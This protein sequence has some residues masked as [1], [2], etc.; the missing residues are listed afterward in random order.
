MSTPPKSTYKI[1]AQY[2]GPIMS[3]TGEL[4]WKQQNL[5]FARNGTGKSFL[6]RALRHLDQHGQ[7]N[8]LPDAASQLVS[9]ESID[10]QGR[11][12]IS[13]GTDELGALDLLRSANKASA[14]VAVDTVF[15]VFN[16]EFV[17]EQLRE[18][19]Y[20]LDGNIEHEI[21]VDK[22]NIQ[23]NLAKEAV[24]SAQ[25]DEATGYDA[26][27]QSFNSD[28]DANLRNRANIN[29]QLK[30]YKD[31]SLGALLTNHQAKPD[32]NGQS[33]AL[34]VSELD[35]LKSIPS[36]PIYPETIDPLEES[37]LAFKELE[38]SLQRVTSPS[39]VAYAIK[40]RI[41]R[42]H[43]FYET[44]TSLIKE[45]GGEKCPLC[46]QDI[47][48]GD[49]KA[50]IDAYVAYFDDEE[51]RHKQELRSF[52]KRLQTIRDHVETTG[53]KIAR[54]RK[55]FDDLKAF[56]PSMRSIELTP[57]SSEIDFAMAVIEST[58]QAISAKIDALSLAS[59]LGDQDLSRAIEKLNIAI[60]EN[61]QKAAALKKSVEQSDDERL[62]L[63]RSACQIFEKEF[64]IS[65]W[66][67]L[68]ELRALQQAAK[69]RTTELEDIERSNPSTQAKERVADTF[70]L[71]LRE[72]F[73]EKYRFDRS[74][75]VLTRGENEMTRGTNQT[76]SDGEKTAIAF[77]YFIAC[78]HLKVKTNRDYLKLFL[79]F[80]DPVTSMSFDF[81]YAIAQTL[82]NMSVSDA[83][84]ISVNPSVRDGGGHKRPR[85]LVL[86]HSSYFFNICVTNRVIAEIATFSLS[87]EG[88][89][90]TVA[91]LD[92]Y[93]APFQQQLKDIFEISEGRKSP[94]HSTGNA[95]RS[96]LEA[97]GRFC[98]PDKT[99]SLT[100]FITF[101]AGEDG[102][103][104]RSVLIN[105]LSHG[106]FYDESP[107]PDDLRLACKETVQ[108][109]ERYARGQIEML[110]K[111]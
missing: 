18:K 104:L 81:I 100:N 84:E 72:F 38:H 42:H 24:S 63:Q 35:K 16:D 99:D 98:R 106:T 1:H 69:D 96:V 87:N 46:E 25:Q 97:V 33:I 65:H 76:L 44:G 94:D 73:S 77:C 12:T 5:I 58:Q 15:H 71:L 86:T 48:S 70:E 52:S 20:E 93:V 50:V 67:D 101:L 75:F 66:Q 22:E 9:D 47:R 30:E 74:R 85:L 79:V 37:P 34:L 13:L 78:A 7:E 59:T 23:I 10:G 49:P 91:R 68:V 45:N 88:A 64:A 110:K 83:G 55:T 51:Q 108:V 80:D 4:S 60:E 90:H 61:S 31:L 109:V 2:I 92:Q 107:Q 21:A 40:E 36:D 41:E 29:R 6:S 62:A 17:H 39:T 14:T 19:S 103:Q 102:I 57:C 32:L 111:L 105:N 11:F 82:K 28:K 89:T 3:L 26:L 56:V 27:N 95:V 43:D 53:R 54:Q 8:E